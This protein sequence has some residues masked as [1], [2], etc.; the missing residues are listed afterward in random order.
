MRFA[1]KK[2]SD[3]Q[4]EIEIE[5]SPKELDGY[6]NLAVLSLGEKLEVEGFRKGKAPREIVEE[7]IGKENI[8]VEAADLAIK[9]NYG[10]VILENKIE[11]ISEPKIDILK[12]ARGNPLIF[13]VKVAILPEIK[14]PDY[15]KIASQV[16]KNK[17]FV[18]ENEVDKTLE[19][20]RKSRAKFTL[21]NG[22]VQLGDFVEIEYRSLQIPELNQQ[23]WQKDAFILGEAH[24]IPGFEKE[25]IGMEAGKEKEISLV[26]PEDHHLKNLAGKKVGFLVKMI[27]VKKVEFPEINDQFAKNLGD[28]EN[29]EGLRKS[30]REELNMEKEQA[31]TQKI[32][33]EILQKIGEKTNLE[34]PGVLTNLQ[35]DRMMDDLR[36]NVSEN[37]KIS[38]EEYLGQIKKNEQELRNS[39]LEEAKKRVRNFLILKKIGEKEKI[40]VSEKEIFEETNKILKRYP[41]AKKAEKE[42][43]P[44]KLKLYTE[45]VIRN[46]KIFQL[47]EGSAR[48]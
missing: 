3:S 18:E 21:K 7:K 44:D 5:I 25:I 2:S 19:W 6:I 20:F 45:E 34:I 27:S 43:D 46:E 23:K 12:L 13:R 17:V 26:I 4:A 47:F 37:L 33:N 35:A 1:I 16:K 8:L 10:K 42:L 41:D 24:F 31:E 11:A 29:L 28:F 15:K 39:F 30:I 14:L 36:H 40:E 22:P 48:P 32:R 38:F 9:E